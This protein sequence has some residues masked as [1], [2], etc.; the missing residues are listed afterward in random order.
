MKGIFFPNTFSEWD[1]MDIQLLG[2]NNA[3]NSFFARSWLSSKL[4]YLRILITMQLQILLYFLCGE[5]KQLQ[6]PMF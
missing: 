5:E 1:I 6:G 3:T 4:A 2:H